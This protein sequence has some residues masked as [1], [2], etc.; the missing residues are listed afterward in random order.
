MKRSILLLMIIAAAG[1]QAATVAKGKA[2]RTSAL[3]ALE[4][5]PQDPA[6]GARRLRQQTDADGDR[7]ADVL[8]VEAESGSG[9]STR[10]V[11]LEMANGG[12]VHR[13]DAEFDFTSM[14]Q[15]VSIPGVVSDA[16]EAVQSL[17]EDA[18][19]GVV[20]DTPDSALAWLLREPRSLEWVAGPLRMPPNYATRDPAAPRQA[21]LYYKGLTHF[22]TGRPIE[23]T[24]GYQRRVWT[25]DGRQVVSTRHGAV[26]VE[27]ANR[28][29]AWLYIFSGSSEDKLRWPSIGQ[30]RMEGEDLILQLERRG[31]PPARGT[32][33]IS[34]STGDVAEEW[35]PEPVSPD[36]A[37]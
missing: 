8:I 13:A 21:W 9:F 12:G 22:S 30:A 1:S 26:L 36:A 33:R 2:C 28:R 15:R 7:A 24:S 23:L 27:P 35:I 4:S 16:P 19:F 29:H 14:L 10:S 31:W 32:A 20:C 17:I 6:T 34:L 18:L 25:S 11:R 3:P 37:E 5:W